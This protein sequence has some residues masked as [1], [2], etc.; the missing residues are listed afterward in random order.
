MNT[1][2]I[3]AAEPASAPPKTC[4]LLNSNARDGVFQLM[5][6]SGSVNGTIFF[7][8]EQAGQLARQI[9][10]DLKD[11]PVRMA[12]TAKATKGRSA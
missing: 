11:L 10:K 1:P 8:A 3:P 4:L 9:R 2:T 6:M 12:K 7:T 5:F